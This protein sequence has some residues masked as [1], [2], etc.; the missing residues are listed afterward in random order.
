[1][2]GVQAAYTFAHCD[3]AIFRSLSSAILAQGISL[4]AQ[5]TLDIMSIENKYAM[6]NTR[7][8]PC[9]VKVYCHL[10][11]KDT[12]NQSG[13]QST[14]WVNPLTSLTTVLANTGSAVY[15]YPGISFRDCRDSQ[16]QVY[17]KQLWCKKFWLAAGQAKTLSVRSKNRNVI[18]GQFADTNTVGLKGL[19]KFITVFIC[20]GPAKDTG[21][22]QSCLSRATVDCLHTVRWEVRNTGDIMQDTKYISTAGPYPTSVGVR[23]ALYTASSNNSA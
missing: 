23:W 10:A 21:G 18:C 19:T 15:T 5:D 17:Y 12:T 1:V 2:G 4:V 14:L 9:Y 3:G 6:V 13:E 7:Q 11:K 22:T 20:G 16:L 8:A